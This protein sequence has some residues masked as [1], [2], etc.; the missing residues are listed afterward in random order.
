MLLLDKQA[1]VAQLQK[2][3]LVIA[4]QAHADAAKRSAINDTDKFYREK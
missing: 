1:V 4:E 2:I 3:D